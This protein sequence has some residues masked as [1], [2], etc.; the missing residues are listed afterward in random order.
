MQSRPFLWSKFV[1]NLFDFASDGRHDGDKS[2]LND[3]GLVSYDRRTKKDAF[4]FYKANWSDDPVL[5]LT[6][7]RFIA[8]TDPITEVKVYS[9][10]D[11]VELKVNGRSLGSVT[12]PTSS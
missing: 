4:Y 3:K 5:H 11:S 6:D 9:N 12:D 10:F 7:R 8:R 1:W 2:G